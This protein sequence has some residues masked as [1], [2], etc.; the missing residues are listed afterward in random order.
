MAKLEE[1]VFKQVPASLVQFKDDI[2][3]LVNYGKYAFPITEA[4][5][6]WNTGEGEM[7]FYANTAGAFPPYR[8]YVRLVSSWI[9]FASADS[10]GNQ[11]GGNPGLPFF[12]IQYNSAGFFAGDTGMLLFPRTGLF[13]NQG[14]K[15]VFDYADTANAGQTY[16][17]FNTSNTYHETY[18]DGEIRLQM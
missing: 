6:A 11:L 15:L 16:E 2:R 7:A 13:L 17:T 14:Y 18:V 10:G 1:Y 12:S 8:I 9:V 3:D 4:V 5:P